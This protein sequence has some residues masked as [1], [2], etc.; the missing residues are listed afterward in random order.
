[1]KL[2]ALHYMRAVVPARSAAHLA[3]PVAKRRSK[4]EDR[5]L[6]SIRKFDLLLFRC[7]SLLGGHGCGRNVVD[8]DESPCARLAAPSGSPRARALVVVASGQVLERVELFEY[9]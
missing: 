4:A 7:Y 3:R 6:D 9:Y 1:M 5:D 2:H 8:V